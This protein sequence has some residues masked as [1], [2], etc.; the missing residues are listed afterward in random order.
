MIGESRLSEAVLLKRVQVQSILIWTKRATSAGQIL[1][2]AFK[3]LES[4]NKTE[5]K[6]FFFHFYGSYFVTICYI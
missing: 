5:Y 4:N 6:L 2:A 1:C 3:W